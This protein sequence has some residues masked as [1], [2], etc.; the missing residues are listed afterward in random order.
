[1]AIYHEKTKAKILEIQ[2][3]LQ[4][5]R[6]FASVAI[7]N[8]SNI[9]KDE[10]RSQQ[11]K[12]EQT[13]KFR[14]AWLEKHSELRGMLQKKTEELIPM[15]EEYEG[16]FDFESPAFANTLKL[17][18]TTKGNLSRHMI[19]SIRENFSGDHYALTAISE[20]L[21]AQGNDR[22]YRID[23]YA[24]PAEEKIIALVK[25]A[26][27]MEAEPSGAIVKS[28]EFYSHLVRFGETR[29]IKFSDTERIVGGNVSDVAEDYMVRRVMGIKYQ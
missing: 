5:M 2:K 27:N 20:A 28:V 21:K 10:T 12:T 19:D 8:M 16:I 11:Y 7:D 4:D 13:E 24:A 22:D 15:E 14:L 9:A 18:E 29:G 3:V 17:I 25:E 6:H 23:E 26:K 1:M